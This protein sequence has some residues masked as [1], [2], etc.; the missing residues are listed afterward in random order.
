MLKR[1]VCTR[2]SLSDFIDNHKRKRNEKVLKTGER[3][4]KSASV[5]YRSKS[6]IAYWLKRD[7]LNW[8]LNVL[9]LKNR[10]YLGVI[11]QS[12]CSNILT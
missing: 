4:H 8:N 10:G 6:L 3:S 11:R 5:A 12:F 2:H 9:K 7:K 1:L